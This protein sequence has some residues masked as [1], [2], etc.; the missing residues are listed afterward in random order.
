MQKKNRQEIVF[1]GTNH[2][3]KEDSKVIR[4]IGSEWKKFLN[5]T[6][7][8][9]RM[10]LVE[11]G[12]ILGPFKNTSAAI[13]RFGEMGYAMHLAQQAGVALESSEPSD[14]FLV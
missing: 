6:K 9:K 11:G 14:A 3:S 2:T 7:S 12:V 4:T 1:I 10:A 5:L 13:K 8:R